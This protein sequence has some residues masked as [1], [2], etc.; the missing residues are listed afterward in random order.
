[1]CYKAIFSG[2]VQGPGTLQVSDTTG[3]TRLINANEGALAAFATGPARLINT[4]D[5]PPVVFFNVSAHVF[6]P[7]NEGRIMGILPAEKRI[8][9]GL[10]GL[11]VMDPQVSEY[12]Y[13][14]Q[15]FL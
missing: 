12:S 3:L 11:E 9:K 6:S 10:P 15:V 8:A 5:M 13:R 1:M 14:S 4:T 2:I 7:N